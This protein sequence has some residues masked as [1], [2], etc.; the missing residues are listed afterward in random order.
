M[1]VQFLDDFAGKFAGHRIA[2]SA[3]EV[4]DV[5]DDAGEELIKQGFAVRMDEPEPEKPKRRK[6][7]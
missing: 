4:A 5:P 1:Q 6:V 3:G 7:I 2:G